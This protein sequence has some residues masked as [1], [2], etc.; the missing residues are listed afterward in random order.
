MLIEAY[1]QLEKNEDELKY[2]NSVLTNILNAD[3]YDEIEEIKN[4]LMETGY[5]KFKK[6][7]Q[8]KNR[9]SKT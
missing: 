5:L 2:L 6:S 3:S 1:I 9:S 7:S 8:K 4:E